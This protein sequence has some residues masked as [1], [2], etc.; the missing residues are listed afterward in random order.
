MTPIVSQATKPTACRA[1]ACHEHGATEAATKG[2]SAKRNPIIMVT[3][4]PVRHSRDQM[5]RRT[6]VAGVCLERYR[7]SLSRPCGLS[8]HALSPDVRLERQR[9]SLSRP[10]GLLNHALSPCVRLERYRRSLLPP[11]AGDNK[12]V[13]GSAGISARETPCAHL[14]YFEHASRAKMPALPGAAA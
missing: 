3:K 7:R 10:C 2:I 14:V 1:I 11:K 5:N 13:P 12:S 6:N 4:N 8:N 9:R